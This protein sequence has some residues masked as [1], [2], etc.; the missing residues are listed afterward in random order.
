MT[1][2]DVARQLDP[3]Y[4]AAADRAERYLKAGLDVW[5][6]AAWQQRYFPTDGYKGA[7]LEQCREIKALLPGTLDLQSTVAQQTR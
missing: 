6:F 1:V 2:Q 7:M 5:G 4:A 3:A